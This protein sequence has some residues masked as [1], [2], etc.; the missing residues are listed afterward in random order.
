MVD[1]A[2]VW[3]DAG[4]PW[5]GWGLLAVELKDEDDGLDA[6]EETDSRL[7]EGVGG[8]LRRASAWSIEG[9]VRWRRGEV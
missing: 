7:S 2:E 5:S 3:S 1:G 9:S 8:L 4:R 6:A